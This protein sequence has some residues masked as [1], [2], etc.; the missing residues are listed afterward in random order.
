MKENY[1]EIQENTEKFKQ[2]EMIKDVAC[3]IGL[4]VIGAMLLISCTQN[5]GLNCAET[6]YSVESNTA[7][8][9]SSSLINRGDYK[10]LSGTTLVLH[11]DSKFNSLII[12]GNGQVIGLASNVYVCDKI[13]IK[14][15]GRLSMQGTVIYVDNMQVRSNGNLKAKNVNF[16]RVYNNKG[17]L[18][19]TKITDNTG[20]D[21]PN[22]SDPTAGMDEVVTV[23]EYYD[24][25]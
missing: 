16:Y 9:R 2:W 20:E 19:D 7:M 18:A 3:I 1:K 13:I 11:E 8:N 14:A 22:C 4:T 6:T 25:E 23:Q 24:C 17:N 21:V 12:E 5:T 10:V 15:N